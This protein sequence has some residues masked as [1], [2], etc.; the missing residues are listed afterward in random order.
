LLTSLCSSST[1]D[2][3]LGT[4][5]PCFS[6]AVGNDKATPCYIERRKIKREGKDSSCHGF[7]RRVYGEHCDD[8]FKLLRSPG[9]GS[10]ESIPPPM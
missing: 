5:S 2:T 6:A 8:I 10:N 9:I 3:Y 1:V 7:V 4:R